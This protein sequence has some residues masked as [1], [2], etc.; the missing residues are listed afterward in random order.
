M[1][2]AQVTLAEMMVNGRGGALTPVG[3]HELFERAAGKGHS[4]AMFAL[5]AMHGGGHGFPIDR[6]I[7]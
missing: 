6:A 3:A 4:G 5:G 7:A 1:P 2:P